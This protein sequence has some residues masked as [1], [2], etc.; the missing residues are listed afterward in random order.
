MKQQK[1]AWLL[2]IAFLMVLFF[3]AAPAF[4]T[5]V[6][7]DDVS[8]A[9]A[10]QAASSPTSA[11]S[12]SQSSPSSAASQASSKASGRRPNSSSR[13]TGGSSS[14][15]EVSSGTDSS[16]SSG[17][18]ASAETSS[19]ISLPSVGSVP[20]DNPL[21]SVIVDPVTNQRMNLI[22]IVSWVCILL[23]VLVVLIV[24]FSNR[25]PPRGGYGR[26]R[27]HRPG[28]TRKKHLLN[29][30]YYRNINKF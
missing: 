15:S 12:P 2:S 30:K 4:A 18:A 19:E 23:G 8:R 10:S 17:V 9:L 25:R 22:G 24:V 3:G 29:D 26:K 11:S 5:T 27:Y 16:D 7:P 13:F 28:R 20:E 1:T 21:S 14:A 6:T